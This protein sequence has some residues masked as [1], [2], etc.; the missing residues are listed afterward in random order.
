MPR[1][2]VIFIGDSHMVA[3]LSYLDLP[4]SRTAA[5]NGLS[6]Y[7]ASIRQLPEGDV[8]VVWL[9]TNDIYY[10]FNEAT[11]R[12]YIVKLREK[13]R[14]M[15]FIEVPRHIPNANAANKVFSDYGTVIGLPRDSMPTEDNVHFNMAYYK[16]RAQT[17]QRQFLSNP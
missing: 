10:G 14:W 11:F 15:V 12:H 13:Y 3:T 4:E 16:A 1:Q 17:L 5:H 8:A 6:F 7:Q 2:K 9:G